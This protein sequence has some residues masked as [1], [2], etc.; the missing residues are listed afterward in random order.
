MSSNA[1]STE[2]VPSPAPRRDE[3]DTISYSGGSRQGGGLYL[4]LG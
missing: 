1:T 2:I 4:R 3:G